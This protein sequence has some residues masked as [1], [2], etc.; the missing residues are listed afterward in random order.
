MFL[1]V[2][3]VRLNV[4]SF[5]SGTRTLVATGGWTGSW[6]LWQQPF[7]LLTAAGWRCVAYDHRGS[8]E[9]PVDPTQITVDTLVDDIVGI[10]D[11]LGIDACV[12]AGES[13]GGAIAQLAVDRYPGRFTGLVLVDSA[14]MEWNEGRARFAA[15]ARA[16]YS[17]VVNGFVDACIP[18]PDSDHLRRWGRHILMRAEPD[19]AARLMEVWAD[20]TVEFDAARI[21]VPTLVIHGVDDRIA[22]I[23]NSRRIADLI[24]DV[25]LMTL[26]GVGHVPT[27]TRP[28]VVAEAIDRR[29]PA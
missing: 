5:G 3:G 16:D 29:F 14:G 26:E 19:Q 8:G 2:N 4:V 10:M 6:E 18:E 1:D 25:E 23:D 24:P 28:H 11:A 17:M 20:S 22:P 7:E 21:A 27:M 15:G 12:L 13:T 9:S